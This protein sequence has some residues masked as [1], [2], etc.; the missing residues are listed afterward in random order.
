MKNC[1]DLVLSSASAEHSKSK[2]NASDTPDMNHKCSH[3]HTH[4]IVHK[5]KTIGTLYIV[6]VLQ[7]YTFSMNKGTF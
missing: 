1:F 2:W 5:P 3:T 6:S 4:L 7:V